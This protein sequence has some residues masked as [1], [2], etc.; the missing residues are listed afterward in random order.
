MNLKAFDEILKFINNLAECI[1]VDDVIKR[2]QIF[3]LYFI[4]LVASNSPVKF[5]LF[6]P[7]S[8][9]AKDLSLSDEEWNTVLEV[10]D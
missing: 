4:D 3:W 1:D 10:I 2:S 8:G 5:G 9:V 6:K 7:V